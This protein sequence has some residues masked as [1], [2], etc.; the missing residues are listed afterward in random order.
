MSE[1]TPCLP[2]HASH[3]AHVKHVMCMCMCCACHVTCAMCCACH[4]T[5]AMCMCMCM[6][7]LF[8]LPASGRARGARDL[9]PPPQRRQRGLAPRAIVRRRRTQPPPFEGS[10][11]GA[12]TPACSCVEGPPCTV[13]RGHCRLGGSR[14]AAAA[15]RILDFLLVALLRRSACQ[16]GVSTC[17][18]TARAPTTPH[19]NA[20]R[21]ASRS[22]LPG[23]PACAA[24]PSAA[25]RALSGHGHPSNDR[26]A[27]HR[28][29]RAIRAF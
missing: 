25:P 15:L 29:I 12:R 3:G 6:Y 11:F 8:R 20:Q 7:D 28:A 27:V 13:T 2:P 1:P 16:H 14:A 17:A 18:S 5:C 9:A 4:V 22:L 19:P 10:P 21:H 23:V 24:P 26:C